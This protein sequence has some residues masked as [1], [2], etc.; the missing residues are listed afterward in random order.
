[1]NTMQLFQEEYT[2][3]VYAGK[4][5]LFLVWSI[6]LN[7]YRYNTLLKTKAQNFTVTEVTLTYV[8]KKYIYYNW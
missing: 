1:M 6:K 5:N 8:K 7:V 3:T 2:A 4:Q